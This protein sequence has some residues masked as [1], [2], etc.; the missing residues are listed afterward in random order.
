M[1]LISAAAILICSQLCTAQVRMPQSSTTQTIKQEFGLG[2]IELTY[3]RP[4]AKGRK[5]YGELIPFN[6]LWRTGANAATRIKFADPVE[7][8]GKR[9]DSGTYV[10]YSIPGVDNWEIIINKGITNWGTD[11]Y[12]DAEDVVR[13]KLEPVKMKT[14]IET[15]T[16]QFTDVKAESCELHIMWDKTAII[17]RITTNVK[18]KIKAQIEAALLGEKKPYWQAANYYYDYEHNLS[19]AL[20]NASKAADANPKAFWIMHF[21]AKIQMEMGDNE[22]AKASA[23]KSLELATAEKNDDYI[24]MNNELL[25]KL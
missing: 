9:L 22:G 8:A 15:F 7:L 17:I 10:I 20:D 24:K 16:M 3:S 5:V 25:K 2:S 21:K 4:S 11:G 14:K 12:K 1:K 13:F 18:E 23:K 6:K 19:K